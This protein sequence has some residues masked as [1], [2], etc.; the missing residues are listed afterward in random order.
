ME[1]G[2]TQKQFIGLLT[3]TTAGAADRQIQQLFTSEFGRLF[4]VHGGQ[5]SS[6]IYKK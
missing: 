3:T 6:W 5:S 4:T 1:R 2:I